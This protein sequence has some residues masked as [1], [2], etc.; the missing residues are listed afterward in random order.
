MQQAAHTLEKSKVSKPAVKPFSAHSSASTSASLA[1]TL[2]DATQTASSDLSESSSSSSEASQPSRESSTSSLDSLRSADA[3]GASSLAD[4]SLDLS[5]VQPTSTSESISPGTPV[6]FYDLLDVDAVKDFEKKVITP[7]TKQYAQM[8]DE[9]KKEKHKSKSFFTLRRLATADGVQRTT[10]SSDEA[11]SELGETIKRR[12]RTT[13]LSKPGSDSSECIPCNANSW[14]PFCDRELAKLSKRLPHIPSHTIKLHFQLYCLRWQKS[15]KDLNPKMHRPTLEYSMRSEKC[16][17]VVNVFRRLWIRIKGKFNAAEETC[18]FFESAP[19]ILLLVYGTES[20]LIALFWD[21]LTARTPVDA[22]RDAVTPTQMYEFLMDCLALHEMMQDGEERH[23]VWKEALGDIAPPRPG[24]L[25][26]RFFGDRL[27]APLDESYCSPFPEKQLS[28]AP[29]YARRPGSQEGLALRDF[30]RQTALNLTSLR[31]SSTVGSDSSAAQNSARSTLQPAQQNTVTTRRRAASSASSLVVA[32]PAAMATRS[33][34]ASES[35]TTESATAERAVTATEFEPASGAVSSS[36]LRALDIAS[37]TERT[38]RSSSSS[39]RFNTSSSTS[40]SSSSSEQSNASSPSITTGDLPPSARLTAPELT[41][42]EFMTLLAEDAALR[43]QVS[44]MFGLIPAWGAAYS[45]PLRLYTKLVDGL[46]DGEQVQ[47]HLLKKVTN[48]RGKRVWRRRYYRFVPGQLL[49]FTDEREAETGKKPRRVYSLLD[50]TAIVNMDSS[51]YTF[52]IVLPRGEVELR[53]DSL[54]RL[55]QWTFTLLVPQIETSMHRFA[56]FARERLC[57]AHWYVCGRDYFAAVEQALL[58]ARHEVYLTDWFLS[59]EVYL[60]RDPP[61]SPA[62][63]LKNVLRRIACR[64]VKVYVLLWKETKIAINLASDNA[65]ALLEALDPNVRVLV[66]PPNFPVNWSHH[67]KTVVIDQETAF[68]GGLDFA[69]GRWDD[70]DYPILDCNHLATRYPGKDY[71]NPRFKSFES[72]EKPF[73]DSLDRETQPRMPWHDVHVRITGNSAVDVSR[74]FIQ[75]W[76][77]H[78]SSKSKHYPTLVFVPKFTTE[79]GQHRVQILRSLSS[80]SGRFGNETS[81]YN[82]YIYHIREAKHFLYIENQYFIS[83]TAGKGVRNKIATALVHRILRAYRAKETF[84]VIVV[85]PVHPEGS[86]QDP[87]TLY[88]MKWQYRTINRGHHSLLR[89]LAKEIPAHEIP[90]Y[91]AFFC[92]RNYAYLPTGY[93]TTEQIYVHA[94]LFIADDRVAIIGS[95]NIN[96]RSMV[97]NRDSEIAMILDKDSE[98]VM[99]T[100]NGQPYEAGK[101]VHSLRVNLWKIHLGYKSMSKDRPLPSLDPISNEMYHR[102][103]LE[104]AARNTQIFEGLFRDIPNNS[105]NSLR[106]FKKNLRRKTKLLSHSDLED[107]MSPYHDAETNQLLYT[108]ANEYITKGVCPV[109]TNPGFLQQLTDR[110]QGHVVLFPLDFLADSSLK[111]SLSLHVLDDSIFQ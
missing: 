12:K 10:T 92:L 52:T 80:W 93:P 83:N 82:A 40:P 28:L 22:P 81:I 24:A 13:S 57:T 41:R 54:Q 18:T 90:N 87:N 11:L 62:H 44:T 55:R 45:A 70:I 73:A 86:L 7:R 2:S 38:Q 50:G 94:K 77:H 42:A 63:M 89:Q 75:R 105:V 29:L 65:A 30:M 67:Q 27:T 46:E 43:A 106:E 109:A 1:A 100:M 64:G 72:C 104:R 58:S 39:Q 56:S 26:N 35:S 103:W 96:D 85:L 3:G 53:A 69:F 59:P 78:R 23:M 48:A 34:S 47:S 110:I 74:N 95:A 68:L 60:S 20:E 19:V 71:Y 31:S 8:A 97:G 108:L 49:E 107:I 99:S 76:N 33:T 98:T 6:G 32:S 51:E 102:E 17:M 91:I 36:T 14:N 37:P 9:S 5:K 84:R 101:F 25:V 4:I 15:R 61:F 21:L 111:H 88:L 16:G 66:H 79:V